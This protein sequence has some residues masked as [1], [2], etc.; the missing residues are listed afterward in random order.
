MSENPIALKT[1]GEIIKDTPETAA[2]FFYT[3]RCTNTGFL[4]FLFK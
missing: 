2:L 4:S 1:V 3:E